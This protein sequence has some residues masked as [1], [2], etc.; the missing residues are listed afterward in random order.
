MSEYSEK[1]YQSIKEA[2][3]DHF[4]KSTRIIKDTRVYG[5]DINDSYRITLSGGEKVFVK[6]NSIRNSEFFAAESLGL[7]ALGSTGGIGVPGCLASGVD[8]KRSCSF[9]LLEYV[10]SKPRIKEYWETFGYELAGLH[11]AECSRFTETDNKTGKYGFLEDNYIGSNRQKNSIKNRWVDFYRECRL[12]PQ[13][14]MADSYLN[15]AMRKRF[16]HLLDHLEEYLREPEFPSLLH[17]DLWSGNVLCGNDGKAWI[18]DPAVYAGD[19][20][21]DLAMTQLFGGFPDRFYAAYNERNPVDK[22]YSDRRDLYNLYHLLNH[23]N[24]F[25]GTYLGSVAEILNRY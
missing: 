3:C 18:L 14:K 10:E 22:G 4:G 8:K 19:F 20:E 15:S 2:I 21:A 5:G 17:G 25:G 9:L 7:K 12:M 23:L 11:R 13:I 24:L 6:T 1:R 16:I